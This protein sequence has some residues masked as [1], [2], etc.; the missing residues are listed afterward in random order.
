MTSV[1]IST[2]DFRA[3][4]RNV[5]GQVTIVA[6][7]SPG[8]RSGLTATAVCALTD[9]PPTVLVCVNRRVVAHDT[10]IESGVFSINAL[11]AGQDDIAVTFSGLPGIKGEDR[12][13][14]G[15]WG[16]GTS[17]APILS[18]TVCTLECRIA[19]YHPAATHT[20]FFGEIIA[21]TAHEERDP[22]VYLR[23]SYLELPS[24]TPA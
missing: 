17:G 24:S 19:G 10:I 7:G 8:Q 2:T 9:A 18:G 16:V 13:K 20:I 6:A 23:G 1:P 12:F 21:G 11:A 5:P 14:S 22:L 15:T 4:M 3:L